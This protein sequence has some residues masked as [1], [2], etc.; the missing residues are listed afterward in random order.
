MFFNS[1]QDIHFCNNFVWP[2]VVLR[3]SRCSPSYCSV[4]DTCFEI[5]KNSNL[6]PRRKFPSMFWRLDRLFLSLE[7]EMKFIQDRPIKFPYLKMKRFLL[8]VTS[9]YLCRIME[10]KLYLSLRT[11]QTAVLR[12]WTWLRIYLCQYLYASTGALHISNRP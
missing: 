9:V 2:S 7:I 12:A 3:F 4:T 10:Q 6:L 1:P 11:A 8:Y 5:A